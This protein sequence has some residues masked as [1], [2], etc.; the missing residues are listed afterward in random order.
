[1]KIVNSKQLLFV[2]KHFT[3]YEWDFEHLTRC[4]LA[5]NQMLSSHSQHF[6]QSVGFLIEFIRYRKLE[7]SAPFFLKIVRVE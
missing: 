4:A 7:I 5:R 2:G 3:F 1:M 6:L